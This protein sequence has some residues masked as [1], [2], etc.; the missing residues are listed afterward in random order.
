MYKR[1][2]TTRTG[3][4]SREKAADKVKEFFSKNKKVFVWIGAGALILVLL[5]AGI[6]S[7]TAMFTSSGSAVIASSYLSEDSDM[8]SA[9]AQYSQMEANLQNKLDN[10]ERCV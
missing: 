2:A 1:Q 9:E 5:S 7:C 3:K 6:S 8:L 10:Y 4:K